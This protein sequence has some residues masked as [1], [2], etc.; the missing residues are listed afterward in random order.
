MSTIDPKATIELAKQLIQQEAQAISALHSHINADFVSACECLIAISGRIV[1]IGI[2]KSGHISRKIAAT[3]ASTGSPAFFVSAA[4][5]CH[6]DLGM[7][8]ED[9]AVMMLSNSGES[10]E[11]VT[12]IPALKLLKCP[13]VTL[14][15]D[16]QSTL[17][18]SSHIVLDVSVT[19]E[20]CPLGLAPTTSTAAMLAMGD[21]LAVCLLSARGFNEEDF[22]RS[23]PGGKLGKR[24]LTSVQDIMH[25]DHTIPRVN[26]NSLV[27]EGLMEI[28]SKG[29]GMTTVVDNNNHLVGVF[30]DGDLRRLLDQQ[31][32]LQTT[33]MCDVMVRSCQFTQPHTLATA[34]LQQMQTH[35]INALP[36]INDDNE[37]IGALNMHDLLNA[38]IV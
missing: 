21:A 34:S 1:L 3:M 31:T 18:R 16:T 12:L 26:Q 33:H 23:H 10:D 15:G 28:S 14:T 13:I 27:K 4:E 36:V 20:A 19:K 5:A 29:L 22:A 6:G 37:V 11:L 9:D 24:L 35:K 2:G 30:T 38:G 8:C 25:T 17:A 7:I 32:N